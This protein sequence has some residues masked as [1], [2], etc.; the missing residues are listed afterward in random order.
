MEY[1]IE[2]WEGL[3]SAFEDMFEGLGDVV[4]NESKLEFTSLPSDVVTGISLSRDGSLL[5]NMP[6]H[7]IDSRFERVIFDDRKESIRLIGPDT[8]YTYRVPPAILQRRGRL[9]GLS[10]LWRLR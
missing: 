10:R 1:G 4:S 9:R 7:G 2:N 5:A 3:C 6:L 8:E